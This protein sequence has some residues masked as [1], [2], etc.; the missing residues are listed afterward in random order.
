MCRLVFITWVSLAIIVK[1]QAQNVQEARMQAIDRALGVECAHCHAGDDWKRADKPEFAF[2]ER[3]I[4]MT[5][6]LSAGTLLDL[7]GVTCWTCHRG[8]VKPAGMTR[9]SWEDRLAQWPETLKLSAEDAKKPRREV[10]KNIQSAPNASAGSLAMAMSIFAGAL[11]VGCDHCHVPGRWDSD[12]KPAKVTARLMLHL[13]DEI[14]LYFDKGRQPIM[15]C[16][17]CHQ[18]SVK[19]ERRAG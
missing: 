17:T 2:A 5:D 6:G 8:K 19:P 11:G 14:P 4:K 18:G 9:A 1:I 12:E 7:G 13:F 3:M 15:Q 16:F 10:Y